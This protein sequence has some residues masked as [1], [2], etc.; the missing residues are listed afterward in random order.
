M[1]LWHIL[2]RGCSDQREE[3]GLLCATKPSYRTS[4]N[5][6]LDWNEPQSLNQITRL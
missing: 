5:Q 1:L 4:I 6:T 3:A 2:G